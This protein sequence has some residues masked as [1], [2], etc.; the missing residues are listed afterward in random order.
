MIYI[1]NMYSHSFGHLAVTQGTLIYSRLIS[2]SFLFYLSGMSQ[3]V[4]LW[5]PPQDC[6]SS[7][8]LS[9]ITPPSPPP[10]AR[11]LPLC[12][13]CSP[14]SS[15]CLSLTLCPLPFPQ[16]PSPLLKAVYINSNGS[17][18][19][20]LTSSLSLP[21]YTPDMSLNSSTNISSFCF[22]LKK[23][24]KKHWYLSSAVMYKRALAC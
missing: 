12:P 9:L 1:L 23:I 6:S 21:F 3:L 8:L 17:S 24:N 20:G 13:V 14:L 19:H 4:P 7:L 22:L 16:S 5:N 2:S 10:S 11:W 15:F 18:S